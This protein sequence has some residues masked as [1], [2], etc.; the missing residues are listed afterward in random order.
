MQI[1]AKTTVCAVIAHPVGHS[2][3][4]AMHNA[5]YQAMGLNWVYTGFDVED[6]P[7]ALAGM[8]ALG[9]RG[10]SVTIPHKITVMDCVDEL[11]PIARAIGAVNTVINDKGKLIG[12]NTDG[13]GALR[14]LEAVTDP[15]EKNVVIIGSGGAARAVSFTL[16]QECRCRSLTI[17]GRAEDTEQ[18]EQLAAELRDYAKIEVATGGLS[19]QDRQKY[20]EPADVAV[21]ATPVGM[22]PDIDGCLLS[23]H[24]WREG[25]VVFDLIYNPGETKL[26][27]EAKKAGAITLN[28]VSM[29]VNQGAEQIRRWSGQE[30]PVELMTQ[31]VVKGLE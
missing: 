10:F 3:S 18:I 16:A 6:V 31:A 28:G 29:L 12:T 25:Q 2:L 24:P 27:C 23:G 14:A 5:A 13:F 15:Y 30:P 21:H 20:L 4:P 8:R 19:D 9:I 22:S 26:L 11:E 1:N 7:A 17:I